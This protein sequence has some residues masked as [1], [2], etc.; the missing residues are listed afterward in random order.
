VNSLGKGW[1][2][3]RIYCRPVFASIFLPVS[4]TDQVSEGL[5]IGELPDLQGSFAKADWIYRRIR[6]EV[7]IAI[8]D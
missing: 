4:R 5:S 2:V 6:V 1:K 8:K 7:F 3:L